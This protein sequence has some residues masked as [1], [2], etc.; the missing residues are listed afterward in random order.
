MNLFLTILILTGICIVLFVMG[1]VL[2]IKQTTKQHRRNELFE[3]EMKQR[4]K[5]ED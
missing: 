4:L 1:L 5:D 2:D 3:N